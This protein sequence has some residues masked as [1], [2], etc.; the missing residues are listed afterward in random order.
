MPF[1]G[2]NMTYNNTGTIG[3]QDGDIQVTLEED[4]APTADYV[5]KLREE[6]PRRFPGTSSLSRRPT[7]SARS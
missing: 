5:R 6:L 4:H 2:I 1:S 7:S 3:T